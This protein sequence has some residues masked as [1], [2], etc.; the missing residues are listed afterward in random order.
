MILIKSFLSTV[1][2]LYKDGK[3]KRK[4]KIIKNLKN[5]MDEGGRSLP[6]NFMRV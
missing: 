6:A 4:G 3:K 5:A 2:I 1:L